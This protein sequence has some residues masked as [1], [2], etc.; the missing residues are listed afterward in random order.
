MAQVNVAEIERWACAIGGAALAAYGL[1]QIKES[2]Q[3]VGGAML[4][5][6]GGSLIYR[7][8]SGFC[9]A[10]AAAGVT[11]AAGDTRTALGGSRGVLVEETITIERPVDELYR[12]WRN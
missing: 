1:K 12:F 10:Y 3:R 9:P 5:A 4:T 2:E 7:G 11:T 6:A 8:A